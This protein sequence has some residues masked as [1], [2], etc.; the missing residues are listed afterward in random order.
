MKNNKKIA[1][2]AILLLVIAVCSNVKFDKEKNS[3]HSVV[4]TNDIYPDSD[5][6]M[7]EEGYYEEE[8]S[9]EMPGSIE[10]EKITDADSYDA[11]D[12]VR[13]FGRYDMERIEYQADW[14]CHFLVYIDKLSSDWEVYRNI[15]AENMTDEEGQIPLGY[16]QIAYLA[17]IIV[18]KYIREYGGADVKYTVYGKY[19]IIDMFPDTPEGIYYLVITAGDG[20]ELIALW[21]RTCNIFSVLI[22]EE[23]ETAETK[24]EEFIKYLE[25]IEEQRI[26]QAQDNRFQMVINTEQKDNVCFR[27]VNPDMV[28]T[29]N[30]MEYTAADFLIADQVIDR[31]IRDYRGSD[32]VYTLH[33]SKADSLYGEKR[34]LIIESGD[35][36]LEAEY[37]ENSWDVNVKIQNGDLG[38]VSQEDINDVGNQKHL[39]TLRIVIQ[40]ANLDLS[41][42]MNLTNLEEIRI[43]MRTNSKNVDL[44]SIGK[45]TQLKTFYICDA[46]Y[47]N[48]S[49]LGKLEQLEKLEIVNSKLEDLSFLQGLG[50]LKDLSLSQVADAD[51]SYLKSAENLTDFFFLKGYHIRN[52][53]AL[54]EAKNLEHLFL[55]ELESDYAKREEIQMELFSGMQ[56][57]KSLTLVQINAHNFDL[58]AKF[59]N[60]EELVLAEVG[61][62]DIQCLNSLK[63]LKELRIFGG[64]SSVLTEQAQRYLPE[65]DYIWIDDELPYEYRIVIEQGMD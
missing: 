58:L 18:D 56:N 64:N 27:N 55:F 36:I 29:D 32:T 13:G 9:F 53:E 47:L 31:Y 3:E 59:K 62:E 39:K 30:S 41:P 16:Q 17:D 20:T 15:D 24:E 60:L 28:L 10:D 1:I 45:L 40:N 43:T 2:A 12:K 44:S 50:Q 8:S 49:F 57:L 42:L 37:S 26:S 61:I 34:T 23:R 22:E 19:W 38:F 6:F 5:D 63:K 54:S 25:C 7:T 11:M 46:N 48:L 14:Q 52:L 65:L 51:L 21:N 35:E 4:M 33:L